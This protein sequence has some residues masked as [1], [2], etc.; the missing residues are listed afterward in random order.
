[1]AQ[2]VEEPPALHRVLSPFEV[3]L[4]ALSAMSP[5]FSV[6][7]G[8]GS[9]LKIAGTGAA[10]AFVFGGVLAAIAAVLYAEI[11]AAFP[12]AGGVY[13]ALTRMLGA[14][15]SYP[16]V[17]LSCFLA[18]PVVALFSL[19]AAANLHEFAPALPQVPLAI[20]LLVAASL[21]ALLSVRR[22]AFITGCFLAV[23]LA[24]LVVVSAVAVM[25]PARGAGS[26]MLHPVMLSGS[27]LA[28]TPWAVLGIATVAGLWSTS[29]VSWAMFFAEEMQDAQRRIGRVVVWA[30]AV[31]ALTIAVPVV[32]VVLSIADL[33]AVLRS[34]A[35]IVAFLGER[36][37]P[38][39]AAAV[40]LTVAAA[41]FNALI[42]AVMGQS[43]FLY[44]AARDALF[45]AAVSRALVFIHPRTRT[46]VMAT[47]LLAAGA[48]LL[49]PLGEQSLLIL[50]SGNVSDYLMIALAIL[51]GRAAGTSGKFF[52]APLH[53]LFPVIGLLIGAGAIVAD[54]ADPDAGR[55]S[56][57]VLL[58]VF[59]AAAVYCR[60]RQRKSGVALVLTGDG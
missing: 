3:L 10:L 47:V 9:V 39:W 41:M 45:P 27:G 44:A 54:W 19:G 12:G 26:V 43:R 56:I 20:A 4:L 15:W 16:Y 58:A 50:L 55:P 30:G 53:P 5:A 31:A 36:L 28:P 34:D 42:A 32:L 33:P 57:I 35:P 7:V 29:G 14:N 21:I 51:A 18:F 22:G 25:N 49:I 13:P 1:M 8:G 37:S 6:F 60:W 17:V 11:A 59:S 2:F 38:G 52:A 40:S 46:P 23:E 24:A 48:T